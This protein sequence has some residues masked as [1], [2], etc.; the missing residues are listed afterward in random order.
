MQPSEKGEKRA[1]LSLEQAAGVTVGIS[2]QG[3]CW[4]LFIFI[5]F[6]EIGLSKDCVQIR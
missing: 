5:L 6:R 2:E 4:L 3:N 1:S